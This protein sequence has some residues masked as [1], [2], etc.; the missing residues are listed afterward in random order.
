MSTHD[1]LF[2]GGFV[3]VRIT[4]AVRTRT[5][6]TPVLFNSFEFIFGLLPITLLLFVAARRYVSWVCRS[7]RRNRGIAVFLWLVEPDLYSA[8][9]G[10]GL[11][12]FSRWPVDFE[13]SRAGI[14]H[15]RAITIVGVIGNLAL[16]GYFKYSAFIFEM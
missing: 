11:F 13:Q 15:A 10:F 9:S 14:A 4:I 2:A 7:A 16:L 1:R 6:L 8:H 5:S 3:N 12:Q